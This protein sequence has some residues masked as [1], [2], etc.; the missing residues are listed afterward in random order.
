MKIKRK[1]HNKETDEDQ[2]SWVHDASEFQNKQKSP[3]DNEYLISKQQP[4]KIAV[5]N[6]VCNR[7]NQKDKCHKNPVRDHDFEL[8]IEDQKD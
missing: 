5:N 8:G 4:F 3:D 6:D 1:Q 7:I 2:S